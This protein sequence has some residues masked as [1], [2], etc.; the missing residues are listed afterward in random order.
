MTLKSKFPRVPLTFEGGQRLVHP[1]RAEM[2][3]F[4]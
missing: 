1:D 4:R 3:K 2:E